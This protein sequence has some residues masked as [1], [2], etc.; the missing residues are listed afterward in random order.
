[1]P[2]RASC[3]LKFSMQVYGW[4]VEIGSDLLIKPSVLEV[5]AAS[6]VIC[7]VICSFQVSLL[8]IR[9]PRYLY[10]CT[11]DMI[12]E[13]KRICVGYVGAFTRDLHEF[14]LRDVQFHHPI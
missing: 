10:D 3:G 7:S 4:K 2:I 9:T 11:S 1:M 6:S 8:L 14:A 12:V 13:F 5:S